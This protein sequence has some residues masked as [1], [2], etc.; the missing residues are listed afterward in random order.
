MAMDYLSNYARTVVNIPVERCDYSWQTR[1]SVGFPSP[2][3]LT[4]E[5]YV[6]SLIKAPHFTA[7][8]HT[9]F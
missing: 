7:I 1:S 3:K 6:N 8:C 4:V 5:E 9:L 2:S